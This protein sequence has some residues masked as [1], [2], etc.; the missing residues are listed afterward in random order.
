MVNDTQPTPNGGFGVSAPGQN[1]SGPSVLPTPGSTPIAQQETPQLKQSAA[2]PASKDSGGG[3]ILGGIGGLIGKGLG[4][5]FGGLFNEGGFV[6]NKGYADGGLNNQGSYGSD[7]TIEPPAAS[8]QPQENPLEHAL[9]MGY[10]IGALHQ[11][12]YGGTPE[13]L[14]HAAEEFKGII[15]GGQQ[16]QGMAAGGISNQSEDQALAQESLMQALGM[17]KGQQPQSIDS[18]NNQPPDVPTG[19]PSQLP[20]TNGSQG[21]AN[22][23]PPTNPSMRAMQPR[24]FADGG[25][26]MAPPQGMPPGAGPGGD[27]PLGPGE[28]FQGDGS[29]KGPG[30][31]QDDAIP[32]KLSNG[33][34]VMSA[35]ATQFF[36]VDKL[37]QMNEKGKQGFMQALHQVDQNQQT[38]QGAPGAPPGGAMPP[39]GTPPAQPPM[40]AMQ[41]PPM[42][43]MGQPPMRSG[44]PAMRPKSSGYMGT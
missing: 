16:T 31:P 42:P 26:P 12:K 6:G 23:M 8:P 37:V 39:G 27:K 7:Q 35:P 25:P 34:F 33:E 22:A 29:V 9:A 40:G 20:Q 43:S 19:M 2:A 5:I 13:T 21:F 24:G 15:S 11:S 28:V 1:P 10:L 44:G 18:T 38:P 14:G 30:G 32:A 17:D 41:K 3:G 36:G 4:A